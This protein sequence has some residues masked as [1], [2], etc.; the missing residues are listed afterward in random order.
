M[1]HNNH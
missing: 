1:Q